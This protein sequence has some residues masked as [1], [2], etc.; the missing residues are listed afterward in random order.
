M[1]IHIVA[2][3]SHA[4]GYFCLLLRWDSY[5]TPTPCGQLVHR[6]STIQ[7]IFDCPVTNSGP[8]DSPASAA[9]AGVVVV[10]SGILITTASKA[11]DWE[12]CCAMATGICQVDLSTQA[13]L[14]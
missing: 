12:R 13:K 9:A 3:I 7:E 8:V 1:K 14:K 6:C 2:A 10:T 4:F 11:S 5:S